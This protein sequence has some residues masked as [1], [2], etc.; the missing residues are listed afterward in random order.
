M[1][2]RSCQ[3]SPSERKIS[4][5]TYR[6]K[7]ENGRSRPDAR[8]CTGG[9][10]IVQGGRPTGTGRGTQDALR[11]TVFK[12]AD[13]VLTKVRA[14]LHT[15]MGVR[16]TCYMRVRGAYM[17]VR[18]AYMRVR[19]AY[20][21]VQ[22]AHIVANLHIA[23]NLAGIMHGPV[24]WQLVM[25][26]VRRTS[27]PVLGLWSWRCSRGGAGGGTRRRVEWAMPGARGRTMIDDVATSYG[28]GIERRLAVGSGSATLCHQGT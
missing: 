4:G 11:D 16:K 5:S 18:G 8:F 1:S 17:R 22:G 13:P 26:V 24:P 27:P 20:M 7:R 12:C 25:L 3:T 19:G 6:K 23:V 14:H 9:R 2:A 10:E 15:G 21:R 28:H